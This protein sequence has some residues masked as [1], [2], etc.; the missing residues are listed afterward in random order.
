M[1]PLPMRLGVPTA[2]QVGSA[3]VL[4]KKKENGKKKIALFSE[5]GQCI[6]L[7]AILACNKRKNRQR[8]RRHVQPKSALGRRTKSPSHHHTCTRLC[9][10]RHCSS[11]CTNIMY[12]RA[13]Q[14][15]LRPMINMKPLADCCF[16]TTLLNF[17]LFGFPICCSP[18]LC[19]IATS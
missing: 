11:F 17:C 4:P 18:V 5:S 10:S 2:C 16:I 19:K 14:E 3:I 1:G 9:L 8:R 7:D 15:K 12:L 6:F 13:L